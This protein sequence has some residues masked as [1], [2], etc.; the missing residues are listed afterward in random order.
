MGRAR[1]LKYTLVKLLSQTTLR[2]TSYAAHFEA[3]TC[4]AG[5]AFCRH[6]QITMFTSGEVTLLLITV[7]VWCLWEASAMR[8]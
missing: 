5:A 4:I 2:P 7:Q 3:T 6:A 8:M 1:L